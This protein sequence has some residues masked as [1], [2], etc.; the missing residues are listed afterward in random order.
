MA[1]GIIKFY[2][3]SKGY[4]FVKEDGTD[5]EYFVHVSGLK[6]TVTKDDKV[7]FEVME[8]KK[9]LNAVGVTKL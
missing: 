1:T 8:G 6:G 9:G 4:G 3:E 2:N 5:K 7:S